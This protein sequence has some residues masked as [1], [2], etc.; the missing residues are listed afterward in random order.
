MGLEDDK[1]QRLKR[2]K[3][4]GV[5]IFPQPPQPIVLFSYTNPANLA[6]WKG[7]FQVKSQKVHDSELIADVCRLFLEEY[8]MGITKI[9][10]TITRVY[11]TAMQNLEE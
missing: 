7:G 2:L 8:L 10:D 6:N 11:E 1:K 4:Q 5:I 3:E 9:E